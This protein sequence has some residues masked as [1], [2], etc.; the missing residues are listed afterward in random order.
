MRRL[1]ALSVILSAVI[2]AL[3]INTAWAE[4]IYETKLTALGLWEEYDAAAKVKREEFASYMAKLLNFSGAGAAVKGCFD[5][6]SPE[7][8]HCGD[9]EF[10]YGI[11]VVGGTSFYPKENITYAQMITMLVRA[12][13]YDEYAK[14]QGG[15]PDG[16]YMTA[17][18]AKIIPGRLD[19]RLDDEV[20]YAETAE[21]VSKA[22]DA[23]V[24][25]VSEIGN[26]VTY[27][28][29]NKTTLL[30]L[31]HNIYYDKGTLTAVGGA[32]P[33]GEKYAADTV[34]IGGESYKCRGKIDESLL[35]LKVKFYYES[36][37]GENTVLYAAP[38][39]N[40]TLT[41]T[42][43]DKF[44]NGRVYYTVGDKQKNEK[45]PAEA[46][47]IINGGYAHG[48]TAE[49]I[50]TADKIC[51]TDTDSDGIY[52]LVKI[53]FGETA[54]VSGN[55]INKRII[56]FKYPLKNGEASIDISEFSDNEVN[57][58]DINGAEFNPSR[59]SAGNIL[60]IIKSR[61]NNKIDITVSEKQVTGV[62]NAV[63]ED[64]DDTE[65]LIGNE[66]CGF[67]KNRTQLEKYGQMKL[68]EAY[69]FCLDAEGK[70]AE[71]LEA[72][73]KTSNLGF[74]VKA[75]ESGSITEKAECLMYSRKFGLKKIYFADKVNIDGESVSSA[76]KIIGA[77][78]YDNLGNGTNKVVPK[79]VKYKLNE[80]GEIKTL[81]TPKIG[82]GE[83]DSYENTVNTSSFVQ[84]RD[85]KS[86]V[87]NAETHIFGGALRV[88]EDTKI[89]CVP[90]N[91][92][93][94]EEE[95]N[96]TLRDYSYLEKR[97]YPS[98]G[99]KIE[100]YDVNTE[101]TAGI[102]VLY[103]SGLGIEKIGRNT[104]I[105][106]VTGFR[107]TVDEDGT[108][109]TVLEG[110]QKGENIEVTADEKFDKSLTKYYKNG[111]EKVASSLK[112]GD[113]IRYE[114]DE[115]GYLTDYDKIFSL[116]DE[117][118]PNIVIRGNEVG[119]VAAKETHPSLIAVSTKKY[120]ENGRNTPRIF[121]HNGEANY[122]FGV[123]FFGL[124][125]YAHERS[126]STIVVRSRLKDTQIAE[127]LCDTAVGKTLLID[128]INDVI[129]VIG[130]DEIKTEKDG[131]TAD[132]V[133]FFS[134]SGKSSVLVAVRRA[135]G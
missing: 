89:L 63:Y 74:I 105:T 104:P 53:Y 6:V 44:E 47:V 30:S 42:D 114:Y 76:A 121:E 79:P 64:G 99:E 117:D 48:F 59:I 32:S 71:I 51:L 108:E 131:G 135:E 119:K 23:S 118:D 4:D 33:D 31:Y 82:S 8:E 124:Y 73:T 78:K 132:E 134:V 120:A 100:A 70:I 92:K 11:G 122:F 107:Y 19:K 116:R 57:I 13:G 27:T 96:Y 38:Y 67:C 90:V 128:E 14:T 41:I 60:S 95:K 29:E 37:D 86:G 101:R 65:I 1:K 93:D 20:T 34:V 125:G 26:G 52:D 22:A 5:D 102:V 87:Y 15:Y 61:D 25:E 80:K 81:D 115:K 109:H 84:Y 2:L 113:I 127:E 110:L 103:Q 45:I 7:N 129:K 40:E 55:D 112:R 10:L 111:G 85:F 43:I 50:E 58:K 9:I 17:V 97:N 133:I 98:S 12:M 16:Y 94:Y 24:F 21:I 46:D 83:Y 39:S 35:G 72:D 3:S 69:T 123:N 91:E 75:A 77:L 54:V 36:E 18:S 68:G 88:S 49:D 130:A 28:T 62:V 56:Y 106:V 126:G 66:T